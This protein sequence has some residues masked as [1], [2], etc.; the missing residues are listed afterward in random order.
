LDV[1]VLSPEMSPSGAG[2]LPSVAARPLFPLNVVLFGPPG[3]GKGTQA[4]RFS[5][6]YGVPAVSTGNILR[7]A[8]QEGSVLGAMVADTLQRGG[9][10]ED[11]LMI[12][13]VRDRLARPDTA[14]GFLLDGFPR[15]VKQ[16]RALDAMM[17]TR[18]GVV[19]VAL[20]VMADVLVD[21]L[22]SRG[23]A[24]DKQRVIRDRL[25]IYSR[26]SEP[27]IEH[28]TR[29]GVITVVDGHRAPDAVFQS[30]QAAVEHAVRP[31]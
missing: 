22:S 8:I 27:V 1:T 16:A 6:Y 28:Y 26:E 23:R 30:I 19:V 15:T 18:G 25:R 13:L 3:A 31:T 4:D 11:G 24:D 10:V 9:L 7:K 29:R 17:D 2:S 12:E 14:A 20:H 21:R 5:A